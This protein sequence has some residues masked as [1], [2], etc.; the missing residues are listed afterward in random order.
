MS[1]RKARRSNHKS[2]TDEA[3]RIHAFWVCMVAIFSVS[4]KMTRRKAE[5]EAYKILVEKYGED[6]LARVFEIT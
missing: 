2:M 4:G 3:K 1:R 6:Y 5:K